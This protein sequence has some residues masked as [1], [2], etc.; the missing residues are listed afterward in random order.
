MRIEAAENLVDGALARPLNPADLRPDIL[1][2]GVLS[3]VRPGELGLAV[4][5]SGRTTGTTTGEIQQVDVT[6]DVD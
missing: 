1:D 4:R 5:K 3:G 2:I 6:V